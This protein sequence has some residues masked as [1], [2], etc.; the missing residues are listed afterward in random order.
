M[1]YSYRGNQVRKNSSIPQFLGP[2]IL[3]K[4]DAYQPQFAQFERCTPSPPHASPPITGVADDRSAAG[5]YI[6]RF[7]P[8]ISHIKSPPFL[9]HRL[10]K[11]RPEV[12]A[13]LFINILIALLPSNPA[14][15]FALYPILTFS[16][17]CLTFNV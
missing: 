13:G 5:L 9:V 1:G 16:T 14:V 2:H 15:F 11:F 8:D 12:K 3:L 10:L 4:S 6:D 17:L 7:T